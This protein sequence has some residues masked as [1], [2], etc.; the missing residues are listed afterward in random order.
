MMAIASSLEQGFRD[1]KYAP[2][3]KYIA[4]PI[5]K[6]LGGNNNPI[7]TVP[8]TFCITDIICHRIAFETIIQWFL[9]EPTAAVQR[10]RCL[11]RNSIS[12]MW[13]GMGCLVGYK[14]WHDKKQQMA[15]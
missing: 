13:I 6:M 15:R 11:Y 4:R 3:Y 9:Q 5:Y 10:N 14:K 7:W 2:Q 8:L 1:V 12:F